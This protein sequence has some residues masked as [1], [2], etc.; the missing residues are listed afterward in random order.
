VEFTAQEAAGKYVCSIC[1][2]AY[3]P[4]EHDSVVFEAL[5]T[6]SPPLQ[7]GQGEV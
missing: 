3:D 4:A 2:Y 5:R 7:E 1:G 6:G